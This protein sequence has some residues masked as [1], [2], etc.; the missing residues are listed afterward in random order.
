MA[1]VRKAS[2]ALSAVAKLFDGHR[3]AHEVLK[4]VYAVPTRFVQLDHATRVGGYPVER[5]TVI[6]GPSN[7][8]KTA[9]LLGLDDSFLTRGHYVDHLD[10]ERTTDKV[11]ARKLMGG[12]IRHPK[13]FALRPD[14]YEAA[15]AEVR[16]FGNKLI[17]GRAAGIVPADVCGFVAVDSVKKLTPKNLLKEM[18]DGGSKEKDIVVRDRRAQVQAQINALWLDELVPLAEMAR[19]SIALIAREMDDPDAD[20]F[21]RKFGNAYKVGGGRALIYDSSLVLRVERTFV[22]HG[23]GK[24]RLVYGERHKVTIRKTKIGGKEDK[25]AIFYFHTSNGVL[26]PFGFDRGR[27]VLELALKFGLVKQVNSSYSYRGS[28][29]GVGEHNVVKRL[30]A[31]AEMLV[32]LEAATRAEFEHHDPETG[33]VLAVE[34]IDNPMDKQVRR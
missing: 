32:K 8:G 13:F 25:V 29:L 14:T 23:E 28:R 21:A 15:I 12:N 24:D 18:L 1:R 11:W 7:E 2:A 4:P 26:V 3:P 31:D 27:D 16:S 5:V 17:E 30:A 10:A 9:L 6:H 20:A 34:E 33:E 22:T 19:L